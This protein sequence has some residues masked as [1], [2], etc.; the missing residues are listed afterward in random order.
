MT[1][2]ETMVLRELSGQT[3]ALHRVEKKLDEHLAVHTFMSNVLK[4]G[5]TTAI[6]LVGAVAAVWRLFS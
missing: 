4:Y 5:I 1:E 2:F 3:E 6:G